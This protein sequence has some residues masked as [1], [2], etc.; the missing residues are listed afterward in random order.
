LSLPAH[1]VTKVLLVVGNA[2]VDGSLP[3]YA[4]VL[5][6]PLGGLKSSCV[7][8]LASDLGRWLPT[9][10]T[11]CLTEVLRSL[12]VEFL[13]KMRAEVDW[14]IFFGLG[15]KINA[16]REVRKRLVRVL[17]R[18]GMKPKLTLG[19]RK[20][21]RKACE[22]VLRPK[23]LEFDSRVTLKVGSKGLR[24]LFRGKGRLRQRRCR[25]AVR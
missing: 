16:L 14:V 9:G 24:N 25:W 6:A 15:L 18:L 1:L 2:G 22:L 11:A 4:E 8:A 23:T 20:L 12:A 13:A 21:K 5:V 10:S 3:S 19:R 7:E 17:S